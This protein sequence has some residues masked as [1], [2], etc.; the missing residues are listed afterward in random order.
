MLAIR[1]ILSQP[2]LMTFFQSGSSPEFSDPTQA[3]FWFSKLLR[4]V[5]IISINCLQ[6]TALKDSSFGCGTAMLKPWLGH[7]HVG[8]GVEHG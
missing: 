4:V 1:K 7:G 6:L 8:P 3:Y 2:W 5:S